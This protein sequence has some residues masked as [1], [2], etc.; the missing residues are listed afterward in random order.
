MRFIDRVEI[1]DLLKDGDRVC[2]AIGFGMIDGECVIVQAGAVVLANGNQCYKLMPRWSSAGGDG[3]AAAYRAGAPMRDAEFGNFINWVFADTKEVCQGAE[4][5]LYN[6]KGENISKA[7]GPPSS[8][9]ST[10]RRS[11]S[12]GTR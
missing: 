12:G 11:L 9:T 2:G 8:R 1:I 6:A 4:D 10:P 5:V 3:I 7:S